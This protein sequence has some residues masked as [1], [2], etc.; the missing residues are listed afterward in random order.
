MLGLAAGRTVLLGNTALLADA[1]IALG[2]FE[3][4]AD[5]LRAGGQTVVWVAV[6]GVADPIE[7]SAPAAIAALFAHR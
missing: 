5:A 2:D 1:G 3:A 4:R 7:A 6:L